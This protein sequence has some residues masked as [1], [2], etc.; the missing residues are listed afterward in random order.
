MTA[1]TV[2]VT[3]ASSGIGVALATQLGAR[4]DRVVLAARREADLRAVAERIGAN[5]LAVVTDV[6]RRRDVERL[7]DEAIGA[8]GGIDVWVN[9]AGRGIS[10]PVLDLTDDEFEEMMAVNAKSALYGM[11]AAVR[12]FID[13][14]GKGHIINVSSLLSRVPMATF[15]S[16]YS[17]AKA[18]LNALT[19]NLRVDLASAHPDIAVTLVMP[20]LVKTDFFEHAL[21]GTPPLPPS[22]GGASWQEADEVAAAIVGVIDHPVAELYTHPGHLPLVRRYFEDVG[23]FERGLRR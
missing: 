2:V 10:K 3:G 4:G 23:A 6:T 12:H 5:A 1:R 20:S 8:F 18:A 19:A 14:G 21:H 9:N 22:A 17:A 15:R 16:V 13:R 7:R 11:Q